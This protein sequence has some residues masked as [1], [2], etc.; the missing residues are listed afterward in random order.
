MKHSIVLHFWNNEER[1]AT[2]IPCTTKISLRTVKYNI[3]KIKPQDRVEDRP[4]SDRPHKLTINENKAL[5]QWIQ[6]N[7]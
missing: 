2:T 5:S 3:A 1:S 7:K 4:R 6:R